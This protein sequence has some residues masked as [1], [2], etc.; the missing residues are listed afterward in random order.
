MANKKDANHTGFP[1]VKGT[2]CPVLPHFTGLIFKHILA[3]NMAE[4][5]NRG[6]TWQIEDVKSSRNVVKLRRFYY[7]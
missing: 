6:K 7:S 4:M 5:A 2:I 1:S 3:K